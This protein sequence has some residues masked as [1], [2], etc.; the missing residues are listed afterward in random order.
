MVCKVSRNWWLVWLIFLLL[1]FLAGIFASRFD[2]NWPPDWN[3]V[4]FPVP[5]YA[6]RQP[7]IDQIEVDEF[8]PGAIEYFLNC[9]F[10]ALCAIQPLS[11]VAFIKFGWWPPRVANARGFPVVTNEQEASDR[12]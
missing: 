9:C 4:G 6:S 10:W 3:V 2:Y 12:P 1:G 8:V 7:A 11:V 5:G